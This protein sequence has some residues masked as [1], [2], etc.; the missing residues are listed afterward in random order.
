MKFAIFFTLIALALALPYNEEEER[1]RAFNMYLYGEPDPAWLN[2]INDK[3]EFDTSLIPPGVEVQPPETVPFY[4]APTAVKFF[5]H[6][7]TN[8]GRE[9]LILEDT[10]SIRQSTFDPTKGIRLLVHGWRNDETSDFVQI[11]KDAYLTAGD[12][13]VV[14][15]DWS[16]GGDTWNYW[17]AKGKVN[18]VTDVLFRFINHLVLN[19]FTTIPQIHMAGHSLGAHIIGLASRNFQSPQVPV[20]VGLDPAL[21]WV[22]VSNINERIDASDAEYVEIIHTDSGN[23][24]IA[25]PIGDADFYPNY[26]NSQPGC[27][28][29]WTGACDHGRSYEFFAESIVNPDAFISKECPDYKPSITKSKCA[30]TALPVYSYMGGD[31]KEKAGGIFYCSTEKKSP[32]GKGGW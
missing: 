30:S 20:L 25:V 12:F 1:R 28:W 29:E 27:F 16:K 9:Q 19:K 14:V 15:L 23:F 11:V 18:D 24:G 22:D 2:Y 5:L 3:G 17:S 6:T 10:E 26:G 21:P 31:S 13:N 32:F 4:D 8:D 7:R